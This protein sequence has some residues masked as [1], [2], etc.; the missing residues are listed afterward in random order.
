MEDVYQNFG[1]ST[2]MPKHW[3]NGLNLNNGN[4]AYEGFV[5][6]LGVLLCLALVAFKNCSYRK[7]RV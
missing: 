7:S 3:K 5:R 6:Y 4:F 1:Q 2:P